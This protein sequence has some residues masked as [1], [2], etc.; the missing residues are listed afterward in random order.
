MSNQTEIQKSSK[1]SELAILRYIS[2]NESIKSLFQINQE[3]IYDIAYNEIFNIWKSKGFVDKFNTID[4]FSKTEFYK[5]SIIDEIYEYDFEVSEEDFI[6]AVRLVEKKFKQ[7]QIYSKLS[8][9]SKKTFIETPE[10]IGTEAVMFMENVIRH[11]KYES[12]GFAPDLKGSLVD[13]AYGH[14]A[15]LVKMNLTTSNIWVVGGRPG[16]HKTNR[17]IDLGISYLNRNKELGIRNEKFGMFSLEI[18]KLECKCRVWATVLGIPLADIISGNYNKQEATERMNSEFKH[19]SDNFL[20]F[21]INDCKTN[22][23]IMSILLTH[24]FKVWCLDFV[25]H[26]AKMQKGNSTNEKVISVMSFFKMVTLLTDS[27]LILLAQ[28]RKLEKMDKVKFPRKEDIEWAGDI[29]QYANAISL[30]F[31]PYLVNPDHRNFNI[32]VRGSFDKTDRPWFGISNAKV[33]NGEIYSQI[34]WTNA[35]KCQLTSWPDNRKPA[36]KE[37]FD[38]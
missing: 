13:L 26:Y 4:L 30:I 35:H 29:E 25:Q 28:C 33:R 20:I 38:W 15:S 14:N 21:D 22:E 1:E 3:W 5:E 2:Y 23:E 9:L 37:Y 16:H 11:R 32:S 36:P 31:F 8:Q 17:G 34:L 18:S 24:K 7:R 10:L 19:I 27:L 6:T 12:N